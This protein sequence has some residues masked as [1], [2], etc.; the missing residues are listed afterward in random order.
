[1]LEIE[2]TG[3]PR[4]QRTK[5]LLQQAFLDLLMQSSFEAITVKEISKRAMVN[6]ATFYAHFDDKYVLLD[7]TIH[8]IFQHMLHKRLPTMAV[9][10][11]ADLE[12]VVLAVCDFL[13]QFDGA[14]R[15]TERRFEVLV[16]KE[17]KVLVAEQLQTW[18][19]T[20][21]SL[22]WRDGTTPELAAVMA[23]WAIY[24]ASLHWSR[25]NPRPLVDAFARAIVPLIT[26]GYF[27]TRGKASVVT[28]P[29]HAIVQRT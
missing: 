27:L 25:Q 1:M 13:C 6:R 29:T 22:S 11:Q 14:C 10:S 17:I 18:F 7:E 24:G 2:N 8:T 19:T 26:D 21:N 16:E 20:A 9:T 28:A 3:D 15:L 5:H 12:Q 4:V 23:S